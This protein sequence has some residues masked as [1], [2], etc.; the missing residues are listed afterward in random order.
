M[1]GARVAIAAQAQ[2]IAEA[3]YRAA[4]KYAAE[5]VQFGAPIAE[6]TAVKGML[7]D[8]K[9][10]IEAARA[11]LYETALI[12]DTKEMLEHRI[13]QVQAA[14]KAGAATPSGPDADL[15]ELRGELKQYTR[16]AAL[17]T[18]LAKACCTEMA[19]AVAYES[20]QVHG[21]SGYM[22]DFAVERHSRDARITNI[23]EGT[24]QLQVVAA[25]GGVLG[26]TLAARLGEYDAEGFAATPEL[27]A[28]VRVARARLAEAI[29]RVRALDDVR[30]RDFHARRLVE[31]AIAVS[32]GYLMLRAAQG[33]ARKLLAARYFVD[34]MAAR[35]EGAVVQVLGGEP[36]MLDAL[37]ALGRD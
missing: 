22:R 33:D 30:Y 26:G 17:F 3:A 9:V 31:T 1:N 21:G 20:L 11:L 13:A 27:L 36:A 35:V 8:M 24:T 6:L 25:I 14:E 18:P 23:Y 2:G 29:A 4:A 28:R 15:K 12:V 7:A 37:S 19:N 5:R 16:L 32:C 10:S 34:A